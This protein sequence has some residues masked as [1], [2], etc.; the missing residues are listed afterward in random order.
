MIST[1]QLTYLRPLTSFFQE[2][3]IKMG[4]DSMIAETL[5]LL[6]NEV[7]TCY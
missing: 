6:N 2:C 5:E 1:Q 4:V 3:A 7:S